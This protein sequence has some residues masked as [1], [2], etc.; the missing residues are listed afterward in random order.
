M[1][2]ANLKERIQGAIE[3]IKS[4]YPQQPEIG[5]ILGTG[6]GGLGEEIEDR[7]CLEYEKIPNFPVSTAPGHKGHLICGMLSGKPVTAMEGRF[8]FYEGYS[9]E[10]VTF[11]VR[12]LRALGAK[13]LIVSNAA[14]G[15]N[16][17][18]E[19]GDL[20]LICDHINLMGVN[21]LIGPNDDSLGPRFPDMSQPYDRELIKLAQRVSLSLGKKVQKGVYV[22]VTGPN[23]ETA[24]EYR[25]MR[26]I[27]ADAVGMS[28]IPEV[29]V[30]VHCGLRI[31]GISCITDMCLPDN[32]SPANIDE[33]IKIAQ[34]TEPELTNLIRN[35]V[36][37]MKV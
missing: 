20:M 3:F 10:E 14:G 28:T 35:V 23:L 36:S 34:R 19:P 21:P 1:Q 15:I 27:G 4:R 7:A 12:V 26:T 37:K 2:T 8:H 18:F 5:I 9:L 17:L 31:L 30:G 11:P 33:I 25:F 32:L 22:G 24:A 29:I 6:L 16:P 13:V